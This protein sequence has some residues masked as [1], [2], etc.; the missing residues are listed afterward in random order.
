MLD[1]KLIE[2]KNKERNLNF[3]GSNFFPSF[4]D[5][6]FKRNNFSFVALARLNCFSFSLHHFV[7]CS[8]FCMISILILVL[9]HP[10][11]NTKER[12]NN[13]LVSKSLELGVSLQIQVISEQKCKW[14]KI[15]RAVRVAPKLPKKPM[16]PKQSHPI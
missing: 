11:T 13:S 2:Q 10:R 3:I 4:L 6:A 16:G 12:L 8:S 14:T 7:H 1:I 9:W 15:D 5:P